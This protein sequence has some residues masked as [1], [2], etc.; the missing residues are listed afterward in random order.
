MQHGPRNVRILPARAGKGNAMCVYVDDM[1][2]PADVPNGSKIVSGNWCH[3]TA[4]TTEELQAFARKLGLR[5][6]W[7]QPVKL[8]PDNEY[9]RRVCPEKIGKPRPGSRDHYDVTARVRAKAIR[10]GAIPVRFGCEPWRD[11]KKERAE[12]DEF[13]RRPE[14]EPATSAPAEGGESIPAQTSGYEPVKDGS[15]Y[16]Q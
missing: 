3:L 5:L 8:Y 4:D 16:G 2:I 12:S 6:S 1:F 7:F 9:T 14:A 11:R 13:D 10:L 15:H